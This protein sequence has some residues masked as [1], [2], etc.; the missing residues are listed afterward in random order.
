MKWLGVIIDRAA[1]M[2]TDRGE[3]LFERLPVENLL[4]RVQLETN[5]DASCV[6]GVENRR[7]T[8]G[9]FAERRVR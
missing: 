8:L 1:R 9:E 3:E 6:K 2:I 5:V 7:P 4:A